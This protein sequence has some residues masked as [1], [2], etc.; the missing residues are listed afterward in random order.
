MQVG[1]L[2]ITILSL[3]WAA[4]NSETQV[5]R[6]KKLALICEFCCEDFKELTGT[7]Q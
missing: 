3:G 2:H 6:Q 7:S 5:S 4:M 1:S